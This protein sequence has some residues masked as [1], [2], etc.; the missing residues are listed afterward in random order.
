MNEYI[1]HKCGLSNAVYGS[2][3]HLIRE[4]IS[5]EIQPD[6]NNDY[7]IDS[8]EEIDKLDCISDNEN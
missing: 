4:E 6:N 8:F 2:E 5:K 7:D 1:L 3:D